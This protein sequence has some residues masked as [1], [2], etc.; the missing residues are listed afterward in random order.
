MKTTFR[1]HK[2]G[3]TFQNNII[4]KFI[5]MG[6][7]RL[8]QTQLGQS[9]VQRWPLFHILVPYMELPCQHMPCTALH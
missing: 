8:D 1:K 3:P 9:S 4:P 5:E 6:L 2:R 7:E